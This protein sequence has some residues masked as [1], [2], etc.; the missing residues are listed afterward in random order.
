MLE[1][2]EAA[3]PLGGRK[4]RSTLRAAPK[5]HAAEGAN[6]SPSAATAAHRLQPSPVAWLFPGVRVRLHS[7]RNSNQKERGHERISRCR[8]IGSQQGKAHRHLLP[9]VCGDGRDRILAEPIAHRR[10]RR[11]GDATATAARILA[12]ENTLRLAIAAN[13]TA[14]A[15]YL[16]MATF[17]YDVFRPVDRTMARLAVLF[18]LISCALGAFDS[19]FQFATLDAL[20]GNDFMGAMSTPE[21][22][23]LAYLMLKQHVRALDMGLVFFGFLWL[24]LGYLGLRCAFLPRLIG[25]VAVLNGLWYITHLYRPFAAALMPYVVIAPGV[26]SMAVML[27]LAIKGVDE[28]RWCEQARAAEQ[29]SA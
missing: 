15:F 25:A 9:A 16:V 1:A 4:R 10:R 22:H 21:R 5:C 13:L 11:Y 26:G 8:S 20:L 28:Q 6:R 29:L 23:A 12:A 24:T 17:L 18:L 14:A 3:Q 2:A 19:L 7:T 27:W